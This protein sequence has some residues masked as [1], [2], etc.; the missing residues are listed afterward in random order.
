[1]FHTF[2]TKY[3][4]FVVFLVSA[5]IIPHFYHI[6]RGIEQSLDSN[7]GQSE[8][9]LEIKDRAKLLQQS[10]DSSAANLARYL[11]LTIVRYELTFASIGLKEYQAW[12]R[13][14]GD[15]S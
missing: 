3:K 6:I 8:L 10:V 11:S 7:S 12:C 1:M 4:H 14:H 9:V 13:S 5:I 2:Y 15:L